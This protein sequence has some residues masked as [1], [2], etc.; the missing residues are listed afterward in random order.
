MTTAMLIKRIIQRLNRIHIITSPFEP[1]TE[2]KKP[3][4]KVTSVEHFEY[5]VNPMIKQQ[6]IQILLLDLVNQQKF[7]NPS[8]QMSIN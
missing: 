5:K 7:S 4:L 1:L 8:N 6:K 3:F 2:S